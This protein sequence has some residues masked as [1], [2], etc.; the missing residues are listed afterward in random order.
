MSFRI[1]IGYKAPEHSVPITAIN[2]YFTNIFTN[3]DEPPG[4]RPTRITFFIIN[5]KIR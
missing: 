1:Q 2:V 5:K 3:L 4:V